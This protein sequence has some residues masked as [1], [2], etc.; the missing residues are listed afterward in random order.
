MKYLPN[1]T[2]LFVSF[3]SC[4][5]LFSQGLVS[6]SINH[7]CNLKMVSSFCKNYL[8]VKLI[9]FLFLFSTSFLNS[10]IIN[11]GFDSWHVQGNIEVPSF[12][13]L[14]DEI[15]PGIYEKI[16]VDGNTIVKVNSGTSLRCQNIISQ[17][18]D[19]S[20]LA[21]DEKGSVHALMKVESSFH[22][23]NVKLSIENYFGDYEFIDFQES[24]VKLNTEGFKE[25]KIGDLR[26]NTDV[27]YVF[28]S[29]G[30]TKFNGQCINPTTIWLDSIYIKPVE[31]N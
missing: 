29:S 27:I 21:E 31:R 7:V 2:F 11:S 28:I 3:I 13:I 18:V 25:F 9:I 10:Q 23:P 6:I 22:E 8:V 12:Y 17:L 26:K 14:D 20:S 30:G 4:I 15:F 19:V 5:F 16:L 24:N 1:I